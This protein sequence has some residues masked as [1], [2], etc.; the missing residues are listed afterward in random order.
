MEVRQYRFFTFFPSAVGDRRRLRRHCKQLR[1]TG[2]GCGS[3]APACSL[4]DSLTRPGASA[5]RATE[6]PRLPVLLVGVLSESTSVAALAPL[7]GRRLPAA[8]HCPCPLARSLEACPAVRCAEIPAFLVHELRKRP[9]VLS[10]FRSLTCSFP[11][12]FL[13]RPRWSVTQ[14][15]L[16]GGHDERV[17]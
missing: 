13:A 5:V 9:R 3:G 15:F 11:V 6:R 14:F 7:A 8:A 2:Y 17:C 12:L 4:A 10:F 16:G 1:S